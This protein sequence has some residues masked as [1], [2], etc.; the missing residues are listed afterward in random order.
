MGLL[1]AAYAFGMLSLP[2]AQSLV[3][4]MFG[5]LGLLLFEHFDRGNCGLPVWF[6]NLRVRMTGSLLICLAAYLALA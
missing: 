3:A 1:P 4:M 6:T 2:A 5:H